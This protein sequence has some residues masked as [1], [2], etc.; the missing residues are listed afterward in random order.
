MNATRMMAMNRVRNEGGGEQGRYEENKRRRRMEAENGRYENDRYESGRYE[1][2]RYESKRYEN[3]DA[4]DDTYDVKIRRERRRSEDYWPKGRNS[5]MDTY[6]QQRRMENR[7]GMPRI[8]FD[9]GGDRE[10]IAFPHRG[11]ERRANRR[12]DK[13][14][15]EEWVEGMENEDGSR[16]GKWTMEQTE[17]LRKQNGLEVDPVE[18]WAAMNASYSDLSKLAEKHGVNT[19]EF[20]VDY[21]MEFWFCDKDAGEHKVARYYETFGQ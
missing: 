13:H 3:A 1:G 16:G 10:M 21:V 6:P 19:P 20:W 4:H 9:G 15:A 2:G 18:F 7:D 17:K 5:P 8:G 11:K 14:T 12:F